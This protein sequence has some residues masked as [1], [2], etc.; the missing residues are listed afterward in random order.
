MMR[1]ARFSR[2][3]CRDRDG[4]NSNNAPYIQHTC[5]CRL[6]IVI[7]LT[8]DSPQSRLDPPDQRADV[9]VM[10]LQ[11]SKRCRRDSRAAA[12]CSLVL[13]TVAVALFPECAVCLICDTVCGG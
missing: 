12:P 2:L 5:S 4:C 7:G 6:V 1:S 9:F 8:D 10:T 13:T 3:S 11:S